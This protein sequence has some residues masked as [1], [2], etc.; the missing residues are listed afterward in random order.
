MTE[1][2]KNIG[3]DQLSGGVQAKQKMFLKLFFRLAIDF[4]SILVLIRLVYHRVYKKAELFFTF[5]FLTWS[6]S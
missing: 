4:V 2:L 1:I 3:D 5:L 6:F